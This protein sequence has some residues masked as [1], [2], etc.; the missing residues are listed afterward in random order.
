MSE[1]RLKW[2]LLS[3]FSKS[4]K[5]KKKKTIILKLKKSLKLDQVEII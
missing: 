2:W 5:K 4:K 3:F 1:C